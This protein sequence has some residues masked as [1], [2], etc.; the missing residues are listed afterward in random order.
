MG[1]PEGE[2]PEA[3]ELIAQRAIE[4]KMGARGLRSV[5]EDIMNDIMFEAPSDP[6]VEKVV[7]TAKGILDGSGP[8][9]IHVPRELPKKKEATKAVGSNPMTED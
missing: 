7:V 8:E 1:N 5:V 3:L 4:M 6:T 9:I 2:E